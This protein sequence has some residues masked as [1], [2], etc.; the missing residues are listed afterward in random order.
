MLVVNDVLQMSESLIERVL[1][2]DE[3]IDQVY[4]INVLDSKAMPVL[5]RVSEIQLLLADGII[6]KIKDPH[7]TVIAEDELSER[8]RNIRDDAWNM[9][10]ELVKTDNEPDIY[11]SKKK[12][13]TN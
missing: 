11:D 4:V 5:K 8:Y 2:V 12:R 9:I 3:T 1:W 7:N 6:E 10:C 13:K